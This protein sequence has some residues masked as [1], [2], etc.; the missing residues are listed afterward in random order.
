LAV[1]SAHSGDPAVLDPRTE[2][3][4]ITRFLVDSR[5][6]PQSIARYWLHTCESEA[7]LRWFFAG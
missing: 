2:A 1:T 7:R 3:A 4:K 5:S 6:R